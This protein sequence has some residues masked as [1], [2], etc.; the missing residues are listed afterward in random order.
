MFLFQK[1]LHKDRPFPGEV[2][3]KFLFLWCAWF[4]VDHKPQL[5]WGQ[6]NSWCSLDRSAPFRNNQISPIVSQSKLQ[7][8][9]NHLGFCIIC[10]SYPSFI[11]LCLYLIWFLLLWALAIVISSFW[12]I[13]AALQ[14]FPNI[15]YQQLLMFLFTVCGVNWWLLRLW[16]NQWSLRN[17]LFC[18]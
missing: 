17:A 8:L 14:H 3:I 18:L 9:C 13:T 4:L 15:T 6:L 12:F 11:K 7:H 16:A 1:N 2:L 10:I 5:R